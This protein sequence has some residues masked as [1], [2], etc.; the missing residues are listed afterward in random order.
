MRAIVPSLLALAVSIAVFSQS[1]ALAQQLIADQAMKCDSTVALAAADQILRSNHVGGDPF[2]LV[3]AAD[4]LFRHGRRDE[5][6]FWSYAGLLRLRDALIQNPVQGGIFT[7]FQ[8]SAA[9]ISNFAQHSPRRLAKT[10]EAVLDWDHRTPNPFRIS[11][12]SNEQRLEFLKNREGLKS[13]V[14]ALRADPQHYAEIAKR[15]QQLAQA[16]AS[17]CRE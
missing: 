4:A 7:I 9:P 5:A 10:I 11:P 1:E 8:R 2:E 16:F 12:I 6:V 3:A 13:L 15:D 14:S 17:G